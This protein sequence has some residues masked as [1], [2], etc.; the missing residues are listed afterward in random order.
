MPGTLNRALL[1]AV[2]NGDAVAAKACL[3][4]GA[5]ADT[6]QNIGT[7]CVTPCLVIAAN[8]GNAEIVAALLA[9]GADPD[10]CMET[11]SGDFVFLCPALVAGLR[12]PSVV[13]LLLEAGADPNLRADWGVRKISPLDYAHGDKTVEALLARHGARAA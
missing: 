3:S 12:F 10:A 7:I 8:A 4:E 13:R 6:S 1:A 11:T 2:Q 9:Y 5:S